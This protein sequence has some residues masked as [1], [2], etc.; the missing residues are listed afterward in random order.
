[1]A[2]VRRGTSVYIPNSNKII[3]GVIIL[4]VTNPRLQLPSIV[5]PDTRAI[6]L[7]SNPL[8]PVGSIIFVDSLTISNITSWPLAPGQTIGYYVQNANALYVGATAMFPLMLHYTVE[9]D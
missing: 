4:T 8:N 2:E 5:I 1:M 6:Q 3:C 7:L 9:V